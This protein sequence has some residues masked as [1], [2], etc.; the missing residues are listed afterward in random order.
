MVPQTEDENVIARPLGVSTPLEKFF[1]QY[2][3]FQYLPLN[4][5][6]AEFKRLCKEHTWGKRSEQKKKDAREIFN[7][8]IKEEF[9]DLYGS[10]EKDIKNWHKLC[11]V[12]RINPVPDTLKECRTVGYHLFGPSE[13]PA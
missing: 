6:V 3:K 13:F 1:S 10:D 7:V 4:S 5:P 12:L 11:H 2:T 8:A 9:G